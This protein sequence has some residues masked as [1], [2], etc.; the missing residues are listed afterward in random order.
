LRTHLSLM[1][2]LASL[3]SEAFAIETYADAAAQGKVD[4]TNPTHREWYVNEMRPS[5]SKVIGPALNECLPVATSDEKKAFG[6]VF[7]VTPEGVL[8]RTF[9]KTPGEFSAC[10][11]KRLRAATFP[12]SPIPEFYFALEASFSR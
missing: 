8:K 2:F 12:A 4:A 3:C 6:L 1:L 9:W 5:F 11:E 10:L 7:A